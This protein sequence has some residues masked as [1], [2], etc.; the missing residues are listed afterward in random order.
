MSQCPCAQRQHHNGFPI[1][2][3]WNLTGR[4]PI[5]HM[6]DE[7]GRQL[8]VRLYC[9]TLV[10]V[11]TNAL[12][13][14]WE[15]SHAARSRHRLQWWVKGIDQECN[16]LCPG[17]P[18]NLIILIY[19]NVYLSS[20]LTARYWMT[21][22]SSVQTSHWVVHYDEPQRAAGRRVKWLKEFLQQRTAVITRWLVDF[23]LWLCPQHVSMADLWS[24]LYTGAVV[25]LST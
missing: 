2:A 14:E 19:H 22:C 6:W 12:L 21:L 13:S 15:Q 17:E 23:V 8:W 7:L 10:L 4:N 16:V 5:Q 25:S 3:W 24:K 1:L 18:H 11:L 20:M 9:S